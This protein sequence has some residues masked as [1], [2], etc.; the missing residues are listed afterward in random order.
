[1]QRLS[2]ENEQ[3]KYQIDASNEMNKALAENEIDDL[4]SKILDM[5][6]ELKDR[7]ALIEAM[8]EDLAAK[9]E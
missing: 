7:E 5:E 9:A 8:S 2:G 1:M 6:S 4:K 3:L